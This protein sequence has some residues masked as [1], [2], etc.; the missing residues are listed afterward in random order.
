MLVRRGA[1]RRIGDRNRCRRGARARFRLRLRR[2]SRCRDR[3]RP[4][5]Q[6]LRLRLWRGWRRRWWRRWRGLRRVGGRRGRSRLG[7]RLRLGWWRWWRRRR[8]RRRRRRRG[9]GWGRCRGRAS[10]GVSDDGDRPVARHG[11]GGDPVR[12][13]RGVRAG[14]GRGRSAR[15]ADEQPG[16]RRQRECPYD[17]GGTVLLGCVHDEDHGTRRAGSRRSVLDWPRIGY[18]GPP[19]ADARGR[20]VE[21]E[22]ERVSDL[23]R[24]HQGL[25]KEI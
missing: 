11:H 16:E 3:S 7:G 23:V 18:L 19:V 2:R 14:V 20:E 6:G 9:A 24:T 13:R 10:D 22:I 12:S 25:P 17:A 4:R 1:V 8:G 21:V 5:R 15:R